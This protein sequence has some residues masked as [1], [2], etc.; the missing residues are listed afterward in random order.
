MTSDIAGPAGY[1]NFHI[2]PCNK[3]CS[4]LSP[5]AIQE[6]STHVAGFSPLQ[7]QTAA[8]LTGMSDCTFGR[9]GFSPHFLIREDGDHCL[10]GRKHESIEE[11]GPAV[12]KS[13][14]DDVNVD[15]SYQRPHWQR[16]QERQKF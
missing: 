5:H 10:I 2:Q 6:T 3:L 7:D 4:T 1:N 8:R 12:E 13:A 11:A 16:H 15:E 14:P 9:I